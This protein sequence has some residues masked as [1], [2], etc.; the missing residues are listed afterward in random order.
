MTLTDKIN[1]IA[2]RIPY[3]PE[4]CLY[5][6]AKWQREAKA[7]QDANWAK[8]CADNPRFVA[9]LPQLDELAGFYHAA[10]LAD[11]GVA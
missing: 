10:V 1:A 9:I 7:R 11:G 6:R 8:L 3:G 2:A 5:N 4:T